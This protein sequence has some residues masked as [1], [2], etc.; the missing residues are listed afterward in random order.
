MLAILNIV[1]L[2]RGYPS[3]VGGDPARLRVKLIHKMNGMRYTNKPS[4][5]LNQWAN[6]NGLRTANSLFSGRVQPQIPSDASSVSSDEI[7]EHNEP[8]SL[9]GWLT[10][11]PA[12]PNPHTTTSA[13]RK[14]DT[15]SAA[16]EAPAKRRHVEYATEEQNS[17]CLSAWWGKDMDLDAALKSTEQLRRELRKAE[18]DIQAIKAKLGK[19]EQIIGRS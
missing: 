12:A 16:T 5:R 14:L 11:S 19:I 4:T 13:K 17:S 1:S 2:A 15:S 9:W 10:G 18:A 8:T 7:G 6:Y 3:A